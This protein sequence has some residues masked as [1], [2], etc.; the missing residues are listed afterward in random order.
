MQEG[1]LYRRASGYFSSSV[2]NLFKAE[3]L[4]FALAGG[5]I[6]LMCSPVMS[7]EDLESIS[8]GYQARRLLDKN[9]MND[10]KSLSKNMTLDKEISFLSTLIHHSILE[11]RLIFFDNG[12]GIFH[13]KSGYFKDD[14]E[15]VVSFTGSANGFSAFSGAG[16]FER[17]N[18]FL[19]WE[20]QDKQRCHGTYVDDLW[21]VV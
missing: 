16:N 13:D 5:K 9:L 6:N 19:S 18:V 11:I 4:D 3:T 20:Q 2:L 15:N 17:L 14:Y 7:A 21:A 8:Q 10:I 12:S 1:T